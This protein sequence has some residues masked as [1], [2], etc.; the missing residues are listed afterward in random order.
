MKEKKIAGIKATEYIQ[1]NMILGLGTGSTAYYMIEKVGELV[2]QG[3]NIKAVATSQSTTILANEFKIPLL[4]LDKVKRIDLVIDGVDEIDGQFNAIKGGGG[5]LF[6]EKIVASIADNVIWIM[7]SSKIVDSIGTFPLPVEILPYGCS[8]I[9][10]KLKSLSLKPVLRMK[11]DVPFITDNHNYIVDLHLG[12]DF[13]IKYVLE[14]LKDIIGVLETGLFL[15]TCNRVIIGTGD[16][17]KVVE[18]PNKS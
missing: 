1:D 2:S 13:D 12:K 11:E 5:A 18:N 14:N 15:N 17:V 16:N 9:L 8:H 10:K 6:R 7:D 4:S 3:L